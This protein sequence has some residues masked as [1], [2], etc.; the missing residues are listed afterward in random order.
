DFEGT[1]LYGNDSACKT[2]GYSREELQGMKIFK[3]DP[4]ITPEIWERS[5]QRLRERKRS[6][7]TTRHR[8]KD[9]TILDVEIMASYVRKGINEYSFAFVRDITD[10]NGSK[11]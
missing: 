7:F 11:I 1:I 2:T 10:R 9:G 5:V 3:L 6:F 4:D 8:R